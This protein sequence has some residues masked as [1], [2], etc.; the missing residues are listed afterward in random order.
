MGNGM[1]RIATAVLSRLVAPSVTSLVVISRTG[2]A[3]II[4]GIIYCDK[5]FEFY[6]NDKLIQSDPISFTPNQAVNVSF[7]YTSGP[8][9]YAIMCED[10][11]SDSGYLYVSTA[12][13][14]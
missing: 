2:S 13:P 11:H 12:I 5:H 3:E 4:T 14:Q 9:T 6:F 10:F 8:K 7:E 1:A